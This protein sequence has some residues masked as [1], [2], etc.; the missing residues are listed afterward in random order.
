M[1]QESKTCVPLQPF[2]KKGNRNVMYNY[3]ET[4][5]LKYKTFFEVL[6]KI[7]IAG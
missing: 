3:L 7:K 1:L 6:K 5:K 2:L 4:S